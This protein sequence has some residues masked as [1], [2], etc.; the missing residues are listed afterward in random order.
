MNDC[1]RIL[2]VG[3]YGFGNMGDEAILSVI[4]A[5]MRARLPDAYLQV[6]GANPETIRAQHQVDALTCT[7]W[8]EIVLAMKQS[9]LVI[10]GGGG[11]FFDNWGFDPQRLFETG[12]P[13]IN[14]Y[15]GYPLMAGL[16]GK[17]LMLYAVGVGPLF[18]ATGREV[19]RLAFSLAHCAT[20]RDIESRELLEEI[21]VD[22]T[23]VEVTADPA[24][25]L[26]V[27]DTGHVRMLL[28]ALGLNLTNALIGITPRP[29]D[30]DTDPTEWK[31]RLAEAVAA[32]AAHKK[33][34][35]LLIPFHDR[36]DNELITQLQHLLSTTDVRT[37][38]STLTP[39]EMA[40][41][42]GHCDLLIGMRLHSILF[43]MLTG[44]PTVALSYDPKVRNLMRRIGH[45]DLCLDLQ[46][47]SELG[48]VLT[49]AWDKREAIR[50]TFRR[51]GTALKPLAE[52]NADL[53]C[54]LLDC[55]LPDLAS[56]PALR[57]MLAHALEGRLKDIR[58]RDFELQQRVSKANQVIQKLQ[59][60]LHVKVGERDR[61]IIDL[62]AEFHDKVGQRDKMIRDLQAELH[63]KVGERDQ[64]IRDLQAELHTKVGERDQMIRDLQAELYAKVSA[65]DE[66]IR[67]LQ[68]ELYAKAVDRNWTNQNLRD[69][70]QGN[71]IVS[72]NN[73]KSNRELELVREE[74][75]YQ[76]RTLEA[77]LASKIAELNTVYRS[78][79]WR[80]MNIYWSMRDKLLQFRHRN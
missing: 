52:R 25:C 17:P 51:T 34:Q 58:V 72:E 10:V 74:R 70:L 40:G 62:Q 21:G 54:K 61:T 69:G 66:I 30:F 33:A 24:L 29:W 56:D 3:S 7:D 42:I 15:A 11:L 43:A 5:H 59:T 68:A 35:I 76:I 49:E 50:H 1:K 37:L 31:L 46:N 22:V 53:A 23:K 27:A 6:I 64:M 75:D 47:L 57:H 16:L 2:I 79:T 48:V 14:H 67:R 65:R 19:V 45:E 41:V 26:P 44:T 32:F 12:A 71:V 9:D 73:A 28:E 63:A 78:K 8:A 13:F 36:R 20:V 18:S 39:A 80:A 38:T 60:E 55:N 77:E 4:L